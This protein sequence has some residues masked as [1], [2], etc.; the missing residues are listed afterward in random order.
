M[1]D[2]GFPP[3]YNAAFF[4]TIKVKEVK[5]NTLMHPVFMS[6]Q[7][8]YTYLLEKFVTKRD[9]HQDGR[10]EL[11]PN[12]IETIYP[13]IRWNEYYRLQKLQGLSPNA[14]SFLFKLVHQLLPSRERVHRIMPAN[15]GSVGATLGSWRPTCM[16]YLNV[17]RTVRLHLARVYDPQLN[18]DKA[19]QLLADS[20][21]VFLLPTI[22]V[23]ATGLMTIWT[24]RLLKRVTN[25][26]SMRTELECAVS[27]RRRS[28]NRKIREAGE[29]LNN[30]I[31]NFY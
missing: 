9:P 5:E 27:I 1:P 8:W 7:L 2:P 18:A 29:I 24:N 3:Y 17:A 20:E 22:T 12:R 6:V 4:N 31:T 13:N 11:I 25:L 10:L 19:L 15:T 26:Y 21:E 28:R 16:G 30:L 23:L 14:K